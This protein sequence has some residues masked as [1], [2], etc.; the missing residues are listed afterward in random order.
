MQIAECEGCGWIDHV[1][2]V[3]ADPEGAW[4]CMYC[5]STLEEEGKL[6]LESGRVIYLIRDEDDSEE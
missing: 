4:L 5:R 6:E 2:W 3:D 1:E